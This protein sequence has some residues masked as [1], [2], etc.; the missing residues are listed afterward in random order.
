MGMSTL[1]EL[2]A[3]R[4]NLIERGRELIET[5]ESEGRADFTAEEQQESGR[6]D[7]G[8]EDLSKRISRQEQQEQRERDMAAPPAE[9]PEQRQAREDGT[10]LDS[11]FRAMLT[12]E[13]R[14]VTVDFSER[15][16]TAGTDTAGGNTVPARFVSQLYETLKERSAMRQTNVRVL[17][18]NGGEKMLVPKVTTHGSASWTAEA[19][20][21]T[22]GDPAFGQ[23]ELDAHKAGK[24]LQISHELI[25]DSGVNITNFIARDAGAALGDLTGKAYVAGDGSSKPSGV[26]GDATLGLTA[27]AK[28]AV[29]GDELLDFFGKVIAPYRQNGYWLMNDTTFTYLSKLQD[30]AGTYVFDPFTTTG[31]QTI[32]GKRVVTDPNV[33]EIGASKKPILFGDFSAYY[34]RDVGQMRFERSLDYAFDSDLVTYRSIMRTDGKLVDTSGAVKF[35]KMGTT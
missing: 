15:D 21:L 18:T 25:A 17:T 24:L 16:L 11:Q 6:I 5:S 22:E 33:D 14:S 19:N 27:A 13:R 10:D 3:E 26:V 30:G 8:I 9:T 35:L 28:N 7:S 29:T 34:I 32:R 31:P 2:Y 20:S 12:G 4:A 23:V 1:R